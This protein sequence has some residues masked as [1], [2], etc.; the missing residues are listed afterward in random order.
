MAI[1]AHAK[2]IAKIIVGFVLLIVGIILVPL[3]GPGWVIIFIALGV[4]A[5][6]FDWARRL[7]DKLKESVG[8]VRDAAFGSDN[9]EKPPPP[10][11]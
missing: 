5:N 6:E 3:P 10:P 2:R 1:G 7:R 11:R 9:R 8:K 4:L